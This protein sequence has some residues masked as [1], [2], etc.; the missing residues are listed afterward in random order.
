MDLADKVK[1]LEGFKQHYSAMV[2]LQS[3]IMAKILEHGGHIPEVRNAVIVFLEMES[4]ATEINIFEHLD[5]SDLME[6]LRG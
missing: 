1:R 2:S 6:K 5:L 4:K 3:V